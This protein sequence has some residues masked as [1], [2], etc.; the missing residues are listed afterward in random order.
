MSVFASSP[1]EGVAHAHLSGDIDMANA[2]QHCD[3]LCELVERCRA[4]TMVVDCAQVTFLESSGM[5][6]ML[7]VHRHGLEHHTRVVWR[8]LGRYQRR[9][10]ALAG[11][12]TILLVDEPPVSDTDLPGEL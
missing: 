11:L 4:E 7:R 6:M 8:G 1:S 2:A 5:A 10:L 3:S 12:D 9:V